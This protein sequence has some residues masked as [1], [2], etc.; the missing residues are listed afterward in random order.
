M[1]VLVTIKALCTLSC[2]LQKIGR[3][4]NY[5]FLSFTWIWSK[6]AVL[7]EHDCPQGFLGF[8]LQVKMI[9]VVI[10]ILLSVAARMMLLMLCLLTEKFDAQCRNIQGPDQTYE[11]RG[12]MFVMFHI[13]NK[14]YLLSWASLWGQDKECVRD[15]SWC[16]QCHLSCK[17]PPVQTN[18]EQSTNNITEYFLDKYLSLVCLSGTFHIMHSPFAVGHPKWL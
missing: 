8:K 6:Q 4:S 17:I 1:T 11:S 18:N 7:R 12:N 3:N 16:W 9:S 13:Y 5:G 10:C 15:V 14:L 2:C